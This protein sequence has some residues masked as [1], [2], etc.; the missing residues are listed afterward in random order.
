MPDRPDFLQNSILIAAHPDDEL[1]WFASILQD[2]DEVLL[3]FEDFW[4]NPKMGPARTQALELYPRASVSNLKIPEAAVHGLANW[5]NPVIDDFGLAFRPGSFVRDAKQTALRMMG[6][7]LAPSKGVRAVYESNASRLELELR[8]RL[9]P[10]QNVFT[11][12]PWGEYGHED[13]VQVFRVLD[14][15]REK[16]GFTLWMSNYVTERSLP[17]AL[18]Y[19][20]HEP[21]RVIQRDVDKVFAEQVADIYRKTNTWTWTQDWCWFD[22]EHFIEAPRGARPPKTQERLMPLNVFNMSTTV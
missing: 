8:A 5:K 22:T 16:I 17:L 21:D 9:K 19:F 13:H 18:R 15:L 7:S 11:H 6:R 10:E 20:G 14:Q 1:L 2:V 4:P 12:N 3:V